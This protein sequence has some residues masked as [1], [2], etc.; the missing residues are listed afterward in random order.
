MNKYSLLLLIHVCLLMGC[1]RDSTDVIDGVLCNSEDVT[2]FSSD[3]ILQ[4]IGTVVSCEGIV[5]RERLL[6]PKTFLVL[7]LLGDRAPMRQYEGRK[8][9]VKGI[10]RKQQCA[11]FASELAKIIR[12]ASDNDAAIFELRDSEKYLFLDKMQMVYYPAFDYDE[13]SVELLE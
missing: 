8:V 11:E 1:C 6:L 2:N 12:H 10:V 7:Y 3:E 9:R 5:R 4:K 13:L